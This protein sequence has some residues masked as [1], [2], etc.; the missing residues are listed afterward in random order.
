[1]SALDF[2]NVKMGTK[3]HPRFS[4]GN[5][6]PVTACP[7]GMA[8]F[9][10]QTDGN[11]GN[12]FYDPQSHSF[13]GIRLT[14]QPSPWIGDYGHLLF[15]PFSGEFERDPA[16]RW[17]SFRPEE[18][19]LR[20]EKTELYLQRYRVRVRLAPTERGA[21]LAVSHTEGKGVGI[22]L[23]P[24]ADSDFRI[25]G[26]TLVGWT[27]SQS[28]W[29]F[30]RIREYFYIRFTRAPLTAV[31]SERGGLAL[32]FEGDVEA[33]IATSFI[34]VEQ[35]KRN[36]ER[37]LTLSFAETERAAR[38]KW[39]GYL[40]RI[41]VSGEDRERRET[42]Y[43]CFYRALLYPRIF[44]EYDEEGRPVHFN[45]DTQSTERGVF[46][47]DNGFWDTY[48]TLYPF[49]TVVAP[50][51]VR[52]MAEG[53]LNYADETG[54]LPKWLSPGEIGMMPGTL[55][56]AMLSDACVK[57]ILEGDLRDRAYRHLLKSAFAQSAQEKHGRRWLG[58][59]LEYGYFPNDRKESVNNTCDCA[60]GDFCIAQVAKLT[61]DAETAAALTERSG[62]WTKL[63]DPSS[64]FLRGRDRNGAFREPFDPYEWGGDNCE[65][66]SWQ[67]SFAV[68][69]DVAGLAALYGGAQAFEA[70]LDEL[71]AAEPKFTVGGYGEEIH[72]MSEMA[73]ADF[74]QCAIS[75]QP[76]FHIPWL[77]TAIGRRDKTEYWVEKLAREA[78]SCTDTGFP[79][80]EDNG[81]TACWYLFACMGFY[82]LCPGKAE[83][84]ASKP[85]F[86]HIELCG[87]EIGRYASDV[88]THAELT[89]GMKR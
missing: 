11:A 33:A 46:Y 55:A 50:E 73:S 83:Y 2:V 48:R 81:T 68:Y 65:G 52:E 10:L 27:D 51:R 64:K 3:N 72:E 88:V 59:Y 4:N 79:G 13:E 84:V 70:R 87:K 69:H 1:M 44:H 36:F 19:V 66:S 63:F 5:I 71:F 67:N 28:I 21:V 42:F 15:L 89:D 77:Y 58:D 80:D 75:N 62:N 34:S 6:Y 40:D 85:L 24:F 76:S 57:G 82:P 38:E 7:F 74:G 30:K 45:A 56:E 86:E 29:G 78:F 18:T 54:W 37:E 16:R 61:G 49:L 23:L 47:T 12:W 8:N 41:R 17:S 20:P 25:Q 39:E 60:Y 26:D 53:F 14:H 22:A 32:S 43:T 35:A 9:T 31:P